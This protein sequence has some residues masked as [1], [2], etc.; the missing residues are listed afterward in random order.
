MALKI[1]QCQREF[2]W[3][4]AEFPGTGD[5]INPKRLL[6]AALNASFRT[7]SMQRLPGFRDFYPEECALRNYVFDNWRRVARSFGFQEYDGPTLESVEL[8]K[9]KSGEE[10][11]TQLFRFVDQGERDVCMRPEMTPTL[12]RLVAARAREYRKPIKWFSIS[13]FYR[14]EKPQKGRLR[15][16]YQ[17][18]CDIL[19]DDSPAA[20]AELI[21]LA[22]ALHRVFGLTPDDFCVR[23][24]N[25]NLWAEFLIKHQ[26]PIDRLSE[27][28]SII[29]KL[30]REQEPVSNKK[31]ESFNIDLAE[32]REFIGTPAESVPGFAD[33]FRELQWRGLDS[34]VELDLTI[35]RGLDYYTGLVFEIFDRQKE[36]RALAGGGRYNNLISLISE[37]ETD[38]PAAGFAIG[39]VTFSNLLQELDHTRKRIDEALHA[40]VGAF[41]V[42]ADETRRPEA[43]TLAN[44]FREFGIVADYCLQPVKVGRQFQ[45]AE[46]VGAKYAVVIGQEWPQ[47]R[48]KLLAERTE[49]IMSQE[50]LYLVLGRK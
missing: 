38:L 45:Q 19:G 44:T 26:Q 7:L 29:D 27:F 33:L 20:D 11:K 25:R 24:N 42:I 46:A 40:P 28:L 6:F 3:L 41:I 30:E 49:K 31:L 47:V 35:V 9:K 32:I 8:Y 10:L 1:V 14:F 5:Q 12:A 16:F 21:G 15:E 48:L 13:P 18:N 23:V 43:I 37:G 34:F 39:D 2:H 17:I 4:S 50:D 22:I 36:N